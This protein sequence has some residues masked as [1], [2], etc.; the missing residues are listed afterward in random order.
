MSK[1]KSLLNARLT[2]LVVLGA[3]VPAGSSLA[4]STS[5]ALD[6]A[7]SQSADIFA[8]DR[9]VAVRDRPHPDYEALGVRAGTFMAYP[10]VQFDAEYNDNVFATATREQSDWVVR[11][12][13]ELALESGWSRHALSAYAHATISRYADFESENTEDYGV[14]ANGR[15]DITRASSLVAGADYAT[16]TEPRSSSN[17]PSSTRNPISYR[18][19]SAYIAGVQTRGRTKLSARGDIRTY[20]YQDGRTIAGAVVDQDNRDRTISSF[21]ARGD[22]AVSP[23]T[24]V[25]VQA[26]GNKRDYDQ[27]GTL[28]TPA[29]DSEGYEFLAGANFE[30]GAVARGE[31]AVGYISQDFDAPRYNNINGFGA[32]AQLEWFP[33]Q[34]TTI[35]ATGSRT[36]EDAGIAGAAGYLSTG[37]GLQVDHEL[38]RN[39]LLNAGLTYSND[40][41]E[42]IDRTDERVQASV[43]GTY[44]VN[45]TVGI[46]LAASHFEQ[47]SSGV[48]GGVDFS[49]NR[50]SMSVVA[51]F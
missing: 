49:V 40:E 19:T 35:T 15:L 12:R 6:Q 46:S 47:T 33:T 25:F 41:Y 51:Q 2:C 22:Y 30:A 26:T 9:A 44:L 28:A 29:R 42:G 48:N 37:L 31:I 1:M 4:Q 34:L 13:P 24:A 7:A 27:A 50:L 39:V 38:M 8:R 23:A 45:R 21:T 16:G 43:G 32:R 17:T 18:D 11:V 14:G 5:G 10:R 36:I 3:V 20:D